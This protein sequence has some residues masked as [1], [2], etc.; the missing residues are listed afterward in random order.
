LNPLARF[1]KT[2][3]GR[4]EIRERKHGLQ[5]R[6]R[7]LL[8]M[9]DGAKTADE[10]VKAAARLGGGPEIL[11]SLLKD[12]F[13]DEVAEGATVTP[14]AAPAP[15]DAAAPLSE[16][17]RE[18]LYA[19]KAAMRRYIKMAAVEIKALGKLV[20]EVRT[21]A[22]LAAALREMKQVFEAN[23]FGDA[24]ANLSKEVSGLTGR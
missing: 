2:E 24:F 10:L 3:K 1:A 14:A 22:D 20:D 4:E 13:I 7:T 9:I 6:P 21:M 8:V 23:G 5:P 16:A 19:A 15:A 18:K 12:G 11:Q 17:D